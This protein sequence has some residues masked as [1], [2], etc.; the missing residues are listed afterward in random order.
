MHLHHQRGLGKQHPQH[1]A[2]HMDGLGC[3]AEGGVRG[4]VGG[5]WGGM[6]VV[7]QCT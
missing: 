4:A 3:R 5:T 2:R 7:L 1:V 6:E